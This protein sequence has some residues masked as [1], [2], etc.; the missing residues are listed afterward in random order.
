VKKPLKMI[1]GGV[2]IGYCEILPVKNYTKI[3][4]EKVVH[5]GGEKPAILDFFHLCLFHSK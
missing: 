3:T 2:L 5:P 1:E 4:N